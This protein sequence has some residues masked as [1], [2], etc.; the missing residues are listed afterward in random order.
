MRRPI[1]K[2]FWFIL[3]APVLLSISAAAEVETYKIDPVHSAAHFAVGHL[4]IATVRGI[5]S[6]VSGNV[7]YDPSDPSKTMIDVSIDAASIDTKFEVRDKDLR[8]PDFFDVEKY[9]AIT[10]KSK[11][12]E[13]QGKGKMKI[14]GDLTIHGVT[15]EV[16][17]EVNGPNGPVKDPHGRTRLGAS[18]TTQISRKAFGVNGSPDGVADDVLITIDVELV[19][20]EAAK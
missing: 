17:L 2:R 13:V 9:P 20:P 19:K 3:V 1:V 7:Q 14:T 12:V 11:H 8:S 16:T 18:G 15:K 6:K 10:F 4:G 5:F